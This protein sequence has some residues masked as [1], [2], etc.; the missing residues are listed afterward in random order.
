MA[1]RFIVHGEATTA[2]RLAMD[3]VLWLANLIRPC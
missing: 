2:T 1:S 3:T